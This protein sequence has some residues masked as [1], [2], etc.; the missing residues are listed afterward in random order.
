ML[1]EK[2]DKPDR[3]IKKVLCMYAEMNSSAGSE[4]TGIKLGVLSGFIFLLG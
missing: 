3:N 4:L 1:P 2:P